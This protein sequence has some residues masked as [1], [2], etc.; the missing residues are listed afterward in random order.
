MKSEPHESAP[1]APTPTAPAGSDARIAERLLSSSRFFAQSA[2]TAYSSESWEM[3]YLHL[4][5]AV[6]QLVKAILASAHPSLI[7][8][9]KANFDSLL[10]LCGL[11]HRAR[12][13]DFVAAVRTITATEALNRVDRVADNYQQP[14]S[15]VRL[16]L[17][18]R[19]GVIHVGE[20]AKSQNEAILGEAAAYVETLL[21]NVG[22]TAADYWGDAAGMVAEHSRRRISGIEAL[23]QRKLQTAK[24]RHRQLLAPMDESTRS[25]YLAAVVPTGYSEPFD[26]LPVRCPACGEP[27][28]LIGDPE[29]E[30]EADW[31]VAD[32][33]GYISGAY[34]GAIHYGP[35]AFMCRVCGLNLD[36]SLLGVAGLGDVRLSDDDFDVSEAT[37]FF[38]QQAADD[39]Q[40]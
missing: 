2:A 37:T 26:E 1:S 38:E 3:F 8:D 34:V 25:S 4:A 33:E 5:T 32:G 30:W 29:P 40:E 18:I 9:A 21:P 13:P 7:A 15:R 12:T 6:E 11:G 19:N 17:E 31:D 14:G 35:M 24:E 10:H 23:F 39:W 36:S 20:M 27:G 16:L 22:L 28:I